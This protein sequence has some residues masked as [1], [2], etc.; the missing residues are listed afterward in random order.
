MVEGPFETARGSLNEAQAGIRVSVAW[1]YVSLAQRARALPVEDACQA[2]HRLY[3]THRENAQAARAPCPRR[4]N[5]SLAAA[6]YVAARGT[7]I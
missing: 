3:R 6:V 7:P 1:G 2:E 5:T 4:P